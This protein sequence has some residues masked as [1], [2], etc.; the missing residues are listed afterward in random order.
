MN[1]GAAYI[2]H[3]FSDKTPAQ[4]LTPGPGSGILGFS[5]QGAGKARRIREFGS[6][7]HP[8]Q[9]APRRWKPNPGKDRFLIYNKTVDSVSREVNGN[10]YFD[11]CQQ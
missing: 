11:N 7:E 2:Y 3:N 1:R 6:I 10:R 8:E 9:S 4:A 5:G